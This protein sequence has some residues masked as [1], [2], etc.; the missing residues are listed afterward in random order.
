MKKKLTGYIVY[1]ILITIVFLYCCFP[2]SSM[3]KYIRSTVSK[4]N[5]NILVS[6][7]SASLVF[8]L[9]VEIENL[10]IGAKGAA[11]TVAIDQL[12]ADV[13]FGRLLQ[14]KL[15]LLLKADAYDGTV[16][17]DIDFE[18]RFA[19]NGPILFHAS[20]DNVDIG[21]CSYMKTSLN[22][23]IAGRLKGS[24]EYRGAAEDMIN[25]TGNADLTILDGSIGLLQPLLG[26]SRLDF[27]TLI[28]HIVLKDRTLKTDRTEIAGKPLRGSFNGTIFLNNNI[29][30]SRIAV[31]GRVHM[32][33]LDKDFSV[34]LSGTLARP[35]HRIR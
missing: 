2:D 33:P 23:G 18:D 3:G 9:S 32:I 7:E 12:K 30:R 1:G 19:T 20:V 13:A 29:L 28:T 27:D 10:L 11:G 21:K 22:R 16:I 25:G 24:V 8:P 14:G 34:I 26:I 6:L 17:A 5:P 15:S 35:R 31:K 4:N